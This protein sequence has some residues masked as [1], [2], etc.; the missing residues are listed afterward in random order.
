[1]EG[2]VRATVV[3]AQ[4]AAAVPE[5]AVDLAVAMATAEKA[6]ERA[7]IKSAMTIRVIIPQ[8]ATPAE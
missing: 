8:V 6:M 5:T 2:T 1:M 4:A 7:P 3:V